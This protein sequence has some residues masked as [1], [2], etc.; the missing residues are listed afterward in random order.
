MQS[1]KLADRVKA[2]R[3][4]FDVSPE[5]AMANSPVKH[6]VIVIPSNEVQQKPMPKRPATSK[7]Q[8][9]EKIGSKVTKV[10]PVAPEP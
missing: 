4:T 2:R 1:P 8:P 3:T 5:K 9:I 6:A 10:V 7:A